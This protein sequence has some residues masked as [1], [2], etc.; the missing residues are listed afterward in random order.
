MNM[1]KELTNERWFRFSLEEQLANVGCDID[2]AISWK[3]RGMLEDSH[4]AFYRALELLGLTIADPKHKKRLRELTRTREALIDYF[5]CNN[6]YNTTD[7]IWHNYFLWFNY[8]A[9][10]KRGL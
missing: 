10:L 4:A 3:K 9:A 2:R 1:H 6:E 5:L 8:A 7:D